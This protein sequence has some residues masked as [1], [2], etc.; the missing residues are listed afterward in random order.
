MDKK[1]NI[2]LHMDDTNESS[3]IDNINM[4]AALTN[5]EEESAEWNIRMNSFALLMP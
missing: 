1:Q 2:Q 3:Y 4:D 5:L